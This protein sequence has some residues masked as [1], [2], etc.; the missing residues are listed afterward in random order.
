MNY[1][2]RKYLRNILSPLWRSRLGT[3]RRLSASTSKALRPEWMHWLSSIFHRPVMALVGQMSQILWHYWISSIP[4]SGWC[5][6]VHPIYR[7]HMIKNW[8]IAE[9]KVGEGN[10][11]ISHSK[12][13]LWD[14]KWIMIQQI[15]WLLK[16]YCWWA[17]KKSINPEKLHQTYLLKDSISRSIYRYNSIC[18]VIN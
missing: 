11:W 6:R 10:N 16:V 15:E 2:W 17:M 14:P 1:W 3:R 12:K 7:H 8:W 13:T 4:P 9:T 5:N 18:L